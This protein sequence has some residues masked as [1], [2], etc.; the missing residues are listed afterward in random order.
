M[1]SQGFGLKGQAIFLAIICFLAVGLLGCDQLANLLKPKKVVKETPIVAPVVKGKVIAKVNNFP[2][3]IEQLDQEV[4]DFNSVV[5]QDKPQM[6]ITT[7]EQKV[8]YLKNEMIRRA[9][10]YQKALDIGLDRKETIQNALERTKQD[11]LVLELIKEE[12]EKVEVSSGEIEEYYNRYKDELK[13]PEERQIREIVVATEAE[14][15]DILVRLLQGED[16]AALAREK[17]KSPSSKDG[18]D[19]GFLARG[20]RFVQFDTVAFSDALEV[21]KVSSIFKGP[22]GYYILKLE[23]KRGGKLKSISEMWDD[24]KKGLQFLKQQQKIEDLI[25]KLS[26]EY[27]IEIYDGEIK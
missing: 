9:L 19:L 27:K 12:T 23:A 26:Q 22:E 2:I 13:E 1:R 4:G 11:L 18:G 7:R 16:F 17:S 14:A 15:R 24:I 25:G 8:D 6:K 5:P 21:G 20:K 3:T 10:L